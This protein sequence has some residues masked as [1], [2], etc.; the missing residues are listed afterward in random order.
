MEKASSAPE[1][2][3]YIAMCLGMGVF[4]FRDRQSVVP[5]GTR[6]VGRVGEMVPASRQIQLVRL[7]E[8]RYAGG[9][10]DPTHR[11]YPETA[12]GVMSIY[13]D[14]DRPKYTSLQLKTVLPDDGYPDIAAHSVKILE[15]MWGI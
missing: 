12:A 3:E 15:S 9:F 7:Q 1:A 2:S 6:L 8:I 14:G 4:S 10:I 13:S 11:L 5:A